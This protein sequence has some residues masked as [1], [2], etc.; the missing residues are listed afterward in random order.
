M[1]LPK[2]TFWRIVIA[3][4]TI[5]GV[6]YTILRYTKGLGAVT[7]LSNKYPWGLWV[8]FDVVTGVGLAAGA[9]I[10]AL[11]VYIFR[12]DEYKPILRPA[13]LTGFLG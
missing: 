6:Y 1:K 2:V 10:I 3:A 7:N 4:I 13:I 11:T 12:I 9:F 8:G 5:L